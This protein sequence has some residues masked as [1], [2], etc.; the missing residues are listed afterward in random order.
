MLAEATKQVRLK[1]NVTFQMKSK[2]LTSYWKKAWLHDVF[3]LI[4]EN[5][6]NSSLKAGSLRVKFLIEIW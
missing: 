5:S 6:L 2:F 4:T 3:A 1:P